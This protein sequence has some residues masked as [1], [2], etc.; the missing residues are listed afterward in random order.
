M[1][2]VSY[3]VIIKAF[4]Q[5]KY[6]LSSLS[7][8]LVESSVKMAAKQYETLTNKAYNGSSSKLPDPVLLH[9]NIKVSW[10]S[11]IKEIPQ[12]SHSNTWCLQLS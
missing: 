7:I 10:Y 1:G 8:H 6:I 11:S 5:L 2:V 9:N 4:D 12:G 3:V